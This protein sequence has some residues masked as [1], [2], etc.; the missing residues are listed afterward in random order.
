M[1]QNFDDDDNNGDNTRL[2]VTDLIYMEVKG[3]PHKYVS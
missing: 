2:D 3:G 1:W